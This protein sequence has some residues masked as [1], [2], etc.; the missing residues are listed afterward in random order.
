MVQLLSL[1]AYWVKSEP[2][3]FVSVLEIVEAFQSSKFGQK[4]AARLAQPFQKDETSDAALVRKRY[5]LSGEH[6]MLVS[7]SCA[8]C[9]Y[10]RGVVTHT[11]C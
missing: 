6:V 9:P 3:R 8:S 5:A 11:S 2:Y 4:N 10:R 7:S 1:Q